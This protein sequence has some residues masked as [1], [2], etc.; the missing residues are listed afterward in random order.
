MGEEL[1]SARDEVER[2]VR[3]LLRV[4][5]D[6]PVPPTLR[7]AEVD[8]RV[9]CLVQVWDAR[10]L[11]PTVGA[12][13]RRRGSGGRVECKEDVLDVIRA[14]GEALTRKEVMRALREAGKSHGQGTVAKALADLTGAG[15][16]VNPKDKKGYRIPGWVK[17]PPSLFS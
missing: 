14:A 17:K 10:Q 13:R 1:P 5:A 15:D 4:L 8:G 12:E 2:A 3:E 9:A 11:M 16:L 6:R 7:V